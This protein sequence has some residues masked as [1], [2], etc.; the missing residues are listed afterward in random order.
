MASSWDPQHH[1]EKDTENISRLK[2]TLRDR[3]T[4]LTK[5]LRRHKMAYL[6][7]DVT[8]GST[9]FNNKESW[10]K[11]F[12]KDYLLT[13]GKRVVIL[14]LGEIRNFARKPYIH[15]WF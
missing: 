7:D 10:P 5:P 3:P 12:S 4:R 8:R 1:L 14:T 9:E 15:S 6:M 13:L 2:I 11:S